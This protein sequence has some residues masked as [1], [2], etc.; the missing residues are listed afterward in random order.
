MTRTVWLVLATGLV[1][2]TAGCMGLGEDPL[3]ATQAD[4]ESEDGYDVSQGW[5][6]PSQPAQYE[7]LDSQHVMV[8][9]FDGTGISMA[10]FLP[11]KDGC[12]WEA[13]IH[14]DASLPEAC[15]LPTVMTSSPY[16]GPNVDQESYRPPI[17][18]WLVPQGYAVVHMSL[19]G[20][21]DSEGCME[22]GSMNEQRDVDEMLT[23]T[24]QQPWSTGEI[25]MMGRSY[26]GTTPWYGAAFG[27]P[28]LET[29]V[30]I[31][32]ITDWST[33]MFK[34][35][36]SETRGPILHTYFSVLFGMGLGDGGEPDR[37]IEHWADQ[38]AC[39][40][41][42]EGAAYGPATKATAD[43][44]HAYWE[45][46]GMRE[47]ILENYNGS[48]WVVHGFQDWNVNPSQALPFL[49]QLEDKGLETKAWL[50]QW[51][52][53]YPD[54]VDEHHNTRMDWATET[55]T[56]FDKHLKGENVDTGP[57]VEV[58]DSLLAW[59]TEDT[60]PPRD[61]QMLEL[62]LGAQGEISPPGTASQGQLV[63]QADP[64]APATGGT[65]LDA[66]PAGTQLTFTTDPLE[67]PM[68]IAGLPQ[69]HVTVTPTTP[70][71]GSLFA[72]LHHVWPDGVTMD[73]GWAAI[74]VRN[75]AGGNTHEAPLVPG[76]AV[77]AK[78]QFEP[79]DA[80]VPEGHQLQLTL[81]KDGVHTVDASPTS[82]PL[83]VHAGDEESLLRLPTIER[84]NLLED[85]RLRQAP[86][87]GSR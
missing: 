7:M 76:E 56:W 71:G 13:A 10:L 5:S 25:G 15:Q 74:D 17:A 77:L 28:H 49:Q 12:D 14:D 62:E 6:T 46:R 33:L 87:Q 3:D 21:G 55:V 50:G 8:D 34:N 73:L 79:L 35:G 66:G 40:D 47:R 9:S 70:A 48:V 11:D 59:R 23:W 29:I 45:E 44:G 16:W 57:S 61:A 82:D 78:M 19:R 65:A 42:V 63:L 68:R 69:A 52:H 20:T 60:Y 75:H 30:P 1:A 86:A 72:E 81:H 18:T 43:A 36:T 31:A 58:Q 38:L 84:P 80:I 24:A 37:R 53:H 22:F 85:G 41:T 64:T 26:V 27:N 51:A 2:L 54:R 4:P 32:G 39:V 83:V 67:E